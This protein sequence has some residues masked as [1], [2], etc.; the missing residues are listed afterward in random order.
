MET[1]ETRAIRDRLER[2]AAELEN[3]LAAEDPTAE[4]IVPDCAIGGTTRME[5]IQAQAV[6]NE[7]RRRQR[8]RLTEVRRALARLAQGLYGRCARCEAE[9]SAG[10]LAAVPD[11]TTCMRCAASGV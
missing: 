5:A 8:G 4:S 10:R 1:A 3:A 2:L 11:A 7:G 6:G 9:I